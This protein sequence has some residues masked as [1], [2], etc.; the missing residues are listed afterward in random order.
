MTKSYDP[1][2]PAPIAKN[3]EQSLVPYESTSLDLVRAS[4][5]DI[6]EI[7]TESLL[8]T[9]RLPTSVQSQI[10]VSETE[11]PAP[12]QPSPLS[13]LSKLLPARP[14]RDTG[15]LLVKT[16]GFNDTTGAEVYVHE[17]DIALNID[18]SGQARVNLPAGTY[19]V[20]ITNKCVTQTK[21]ITVFPRETATIRFRI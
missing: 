10:E 17:L 21:R 20:S 13:I 9:F 4:R 6:L 19:F 15:S 14:R 5:R 8:S 12:F 7:L 16:L 11:A 3:E 18:W 2:L 1:F